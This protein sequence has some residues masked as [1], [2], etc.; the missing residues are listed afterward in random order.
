[1]RAALPA[2]L[3]ARS[4]AV[5]ARRHERQLASR[6]RSGRSGSRSAERGDALGRAA[7][8]SAS[9]VD[10][11]PDA[12]RSARGR[13]AAAPVDVRAAAALLPAAVDLDVAPARSRRARVDRRARRR[14]G[15]A[16]ASRR[17]RGRAR[18]WK[19]R[20]EVERARRRTSPTRPAPRSSSACAGGDERLVGDVEP[21][22]G[23]VD[24]AREHARAASGS[25]QMLNSAAGVRF[26]SPI[27]PPISTIRSGRA[28]G[29]SASSSATF[30]S[31]PVG[32]E[33]DAAVAGADLLGEE[34]RPRARRP[35]RRRGG[36]RSGPSSPALAVDVR[37]DVALA[38]ERPRRA[39]G[40]RHVAAA[41]ELEHAQRVRGRLLERL[42]ARDG[43][44]ADAARPPARRAR[45]GARSRRRGP[46]SQSRTI[47][48]GVTGAV[49]RR[50]R[51]RSA[52][53][54][55]RRARRGERAGGAR[56]AQRLLVR[57]ALE[58]R[59]DEA[60]GER[61]AGARCRRRRRRAAARRRATS[62]PSS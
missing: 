54:A 57:P 53:R 3:R 26:P 14:P 7:R 36:G 9:R 33:R 24:P 10:A 41:G 58:Q 38:H 11:E 56:P 32:D 35:A 4:G 6:C 29:A 28:S 21:D 50:P 15:R 20:V 61:V 30:V 55:A 17:A 34:R 8:R 40:D 59:D 12:A 45:A 19:R 18:R 39:R 60:G 49:S 5:F 37:R 48:V 31:G 1:M 22:H 25:A 51:R 62:R 13:R 27:E 43:R 42:V 52:A 46:G 23:H 47:G 2:V 44:H 16:S